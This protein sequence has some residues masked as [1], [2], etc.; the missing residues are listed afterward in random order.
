[1]DITSQFKHLVD[2]AESNQTQDS[3]DNELDVDDA[4]LM[5]LPDKNRI[6]PK[7]KRKKSK[8]I[9][10]DPF[11]TKARVIIQNITKLREFL[12]ENRSAYID[13]LNITGSTGAD[14][15][16]NFY[17]SVASNGLSDLD[18][19]KIDEG[20]NVII[21]N[22]NKLITKFKSDLK[23]KLENKGKYHLTANQTQHLESVCDILENY[24]RNACQYHAKQKAIRVEKELEL[25]KLS[26][27]EL[28]AKSN[29]N[30]ISTKQISDFVKR[31]DPDNQSQN[32]NSDIDSDSNLFP[33]DWSCD[34]EHSKNS[35][36][37]NEQKSSK[38]SLTSIPK[39]HCNE[40]I[41]LSIPENVQINANAS[42][43]NS[44]YQYS[45]DDDAENNDGENSLS[46]EEIQAYEQENEAMYE[47]LVSL[48]DNIQQIENKVVKIAQLQEV[49]TEKGRII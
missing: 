12:A 26:R 8:N 47:D 42:N 33:G 4:D 45:S 35:K 2:I 10:K 36:H 23:E 49:F 25:Q 34:S 38:K 39:D 15:N 7:T 40:E 37:R 30:S 18:R 16:T 9:P 41:D 17:D 44:R 19:D 6:L 46:P 14:D 3:K 22:I 13:V 1:M 31:K 5:L 43:L 48:R 24:L 27:L 20:A 28:N 11:E 32:S 29:P 21:R